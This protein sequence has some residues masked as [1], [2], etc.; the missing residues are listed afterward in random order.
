MAVVPGD[1]FRSGV[2]ARE[3]FAGN[4]ETTIGRGTHRVHHRVVV[5]EQFRVGE[6]AADLG[7]EVQR[8]GVATEGPLERLGDGLRAGMVGGDSGTDQTERCRQPLEHLDLDIGSIEQF[9]RRIA[10]CGPGPYD[11]NPQGSEIPRRGRCRHER[12]PASGMGC[13]R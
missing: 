7:V 13:A 1:E 4:A 2:A 12:V 5:V 6:V 3:V 11:S 8:E 9:L 10:G